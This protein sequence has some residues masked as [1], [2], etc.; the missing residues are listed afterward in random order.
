[1]PSDSRRYDQRA[2]FLVNP[3]E[4]ITDSATRAGPARKDTPSKLRG[5]DIAHMVT[6]MLEMSDRGF[7]PEL[8]VCAT[9]PQDWGPGVDGDERTAGPRRR[10]L[11]R[12]A[13]KS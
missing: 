9:N 2:G 12:G 10:A 8:S 4:V 11:T 3:S 1:M 6:A 13:P 7:T 5:E